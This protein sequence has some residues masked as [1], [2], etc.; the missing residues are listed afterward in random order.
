V[1]ISVVTV[2]LSSE[3]P[4]LLTAVALTR[5]RDGRVTIHIPTGLPYPTALSAA[6]RLLAALRA[7]PRREVEVAAGKG[8]A[9]S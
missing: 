3:L 7:R 4:T 6:K 9:A 8:P 2:I 5:D 1:H